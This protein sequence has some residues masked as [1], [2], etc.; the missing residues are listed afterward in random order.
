MRSNNRRTPAPPAFA[1]RHRKEE[2]RI[3][4][5]IDRPDHRRRS[6]LLHH[7]ALHVDERELSRGVPLEQLLIT[8]MPMPLRI[9]RARTRFALKSTKTPPSS[10]YGFENV[11]I[12]TGPSPISSTNHFL[13]GLMFVRETLR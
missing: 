12:G 5:Y 4:R 8:Q 1:L 2:C 3:R 13:S 9:V 10:W 6:D 11:F 7:R